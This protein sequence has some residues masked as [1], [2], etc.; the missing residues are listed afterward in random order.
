LFA[1]GLFFVVFFP[2]V[3]CFFCDLLFFTIY[4][5]YV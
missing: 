4:L 3:V 2:V 5:I 1:A